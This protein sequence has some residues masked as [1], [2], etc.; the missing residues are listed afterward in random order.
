MNNGCLHIDIMLNYYN[1]E[2]T[3]WHGKTLS[4]RVIDKFDDRHFTKLSS[5]G[6][7]R[8]QLNWTLHD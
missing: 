7:I 2:V 8:P 4:F 6:L 5:P 1:S 3:A